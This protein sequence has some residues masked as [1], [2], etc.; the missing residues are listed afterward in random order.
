MTRITVD[1]E[2]RS[3]LHNLA[4]PLELYDPSGK[5]LARVTPALSPSEWEPL[6]PPFT[7]E[8]LRRSEQS[9]KWFTTEEVLA[10]LKSLEKQ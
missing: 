9:E 4:E 3:K 6:E 7:E 2:L 1:A 5:L 10:H 8:E